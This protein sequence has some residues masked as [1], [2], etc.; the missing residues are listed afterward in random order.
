M[1]P[2]LARMKDEEERERAALAGPVKAKRKK[3][4]PGSGP[5]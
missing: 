4:D 5:G 1:W 2:E 3:R